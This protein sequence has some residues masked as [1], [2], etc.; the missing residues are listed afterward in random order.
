MY[1]PWIFSLLD[2]LRTLDDYGARQCAAVRR[3]LAGNGE[4]L[5]LHVEDGVDV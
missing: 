1:E 4:D 3:S 5:F 2:I